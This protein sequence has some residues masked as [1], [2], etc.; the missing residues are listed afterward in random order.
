ML[1]LPEHN[2]ELE[3]YVHTREEI[4][5][6]SLPQ[7][8]STPQSSKPFSQSRLAFRALRHERVEELL[9]DI[10]AVGPHGIVRFAR[11][12][13]KSLGLNLLLVPTRSAAPVD[14][15]VPPLVTIIC[16]PSQHGVGFAS[17][18]VVEPYAPVDLP[19]YPVI[20]NFNPRVVENVELVVFRRLAVK[21][22]RHPRHSKPF[23]HATGTRAEALMRGAGAK[24]RYVWRNC[25]SVTVYNL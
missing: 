25:L 10:L 6:A 17:L 23:R 13:F 5:W 2:L 16:N 9:S 19:V 4:R 7:S 14:S 11:V 18:L 8:G 20:F 15:T 21:V 24:Q 1:R 22:A 3:L 12:D